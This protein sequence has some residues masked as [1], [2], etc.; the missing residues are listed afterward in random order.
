M[1]IIKPYG[2]SETPTGK[3]KIRPNPGHK[4]AKDVAEFAKE[5]PE[6][7]IKQWIS[8]ID[9]IAA[10]PRGNG[11]PSAEQRKLRETLGNA[12]WCYL[13]KNGLLKV[14]N[15]DNFDEL[16]KLRKLWWSK[17]HPYPKENCKNS[18]APK[19]RWYGRFVG[20]KKPAE[21]GDK[22]AEE[23]AGKIYEHLYEK[24]YR[25]EPSQPNK[26]KG[27]IAARAE[28][29]TKNVMALPTGFSGGEYDWSDQDEK[30]YKE[31]GDVAG[32]IYRAA[33]GKKGKFSVRDVAPILYGQYGE[34]FKGDDGEVLAVTE[35]RDLYPRLFAL[36]AAIKD[37]YTRILKKHNKKNVARI[38]PQDMNK[39]F[40]LVKNKVRNRDLNGLVR[41]GR[42]IHYEAG[43]NGHAIDHWPESEAI[44]N[45]HYRT[46]EGQ[47]EI[48]R[49]EAFVRVWRYTIALGARTLK[50]WADPNNRIKED[51]LL[52]IKND[53]V[54]DGN[55]CESAYL[56]KLPKLPL[57]FGKRNDYFKGDEDFKNQVLKLALNGWAE[58]RHAAFHFKGRDRF[59]EALTNNLNNF[60]AT[61]DA[62][63]KL[64]K[65]D[66]TK[67][68][69]QLIKD[70]KAAQ[71][72]KYY[73]QS[74]IDALIKAIVNAETSLSPLPRFNRVLA[75]AEN[76]WSKKPY[77]LHLPPPGKR[78][79]LEDQPDKLCRYVTAKAIYERAFP[80]WLEK[81]T[82]Q[83][84]NQ[85]IKRAVKRAT[86]DAKKL[87]KDELAVAKATDQ[88]HLEEGQGIAD[89]ID[90]L[91]ARTASELRVQRGY[92]SDA[93]KA[94]QQA[95]YLD[96]LR[97]DV[98]AQAF[99]AYL[100][101]NQLNWVTDE[102][103]NEC[104]SLDK[105]LKKVPPDET[106]AIDWQAVLYFLIHLVPVD[107]IA[108]LRHQLS[109]WSI[110]VRKS[111]IKD[112]KDEV[113]KP[114]AQLFSL[115]LDMHDAK[116]EGNETINIYDSELKDLFKSEELFR[117][118]CP[119]S[120]TNTK[121]QLVP[122]RGLRELWRF[123]D[124]KPL[125]PIFRK[126]PITAENVNK[127]K[128]D[129]SDESENKIA[130]QQ[131]KR[132]KL[133]DE[134]VKKRFS[135][136]KEKD[137]RQTLKT[138]EKHRHFAAHVRLNN[139]VRLHRLLMRVL[140]RLTDYA[141]LW[142]RD[143]YFVMLALISLSGKRPDD[144]FN[145]NGRKNL[146]DG[147]IVEAINTLRKSQKGDAKKIFEQLKQVF[148]KHF[149]DDRCEDYPRSI[150][151]KLMH[152]NMLQSNK[153]DLNLTEAVNDTRKLM[154]YDRKLKNAVTRSIKEMLAREGLVL[155]WEMKGHRLTGATVKTRQ[156][157]HLGNKVKE[158]LH[159]EKYIEMV[160]DLFGGEAQLPDKTPG[161]KNQNRGKAEGTQKRK[162]QNRRKS[163][164]HKHNPSQR[165]R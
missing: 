48:K 70:L 112:E 151:N 39:L 10:K 93:D 79:K 67:R 125:M 59:I 90:Q 153:P 1:L 51:I 124:L 141:G 18:P 72:E 94:R 133:H 52:N 23:I 44:T 69:E 148:G 165:K 89:F 28:S 7:V 99:K 130:E 2:R 12:V 138:I 97:C 47:A 19:G 11:K 15:A 22:E 50:D 149:L 14:K 117:R 100:K 105:A 110:L 106:K 128:L 87:N 31:A 143:L 66:F 114:L 9:K 142:E 80:A 73:D 91:A 92:D 27:L 150:R 113:V 71:V 120:D 104:G 33:E 118:A 35:A 161:R 111:S 152:F 144:V 55:F 57:L 127:L 41:L 155:E 96:D 164:I 156:A 8:I 103:K 131:K 159:G 53:G 4:D 135:K 158:D 63:H 134:W 84:L 61:I 32:Q 34:L 42:I 88:V 5:H 25:K 85:W 40:Q 136:E 129:E 122:W 49:N 24:E 115:Y 64:L 21:I 98:V 30:A 146:K 62:T 37:T 107:A 137:Y 54:T 56:K 160:A 68:N 46:S 140:G 82:K 86:E 123:G 36:H 58:L 132:E 147:Q 119:E 126:H 154:A 116:F 121:K 157:T 45:S 78:D 13:I 77:L 76:A 43:K 83:A 108:Q 109:K 20:D 29:I 16:E 139:H 75:R 95:K 74:K 65:H 81:Q 3:R 102:L 101:E 60:P 145:S 6:L 38:L 162:Y 26:S 163:H 17:I